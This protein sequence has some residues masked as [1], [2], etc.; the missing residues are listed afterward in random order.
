[1]ITIYGIK[2][3]DTC[4]KA[5]KWLLA[6]GIEHRFHDFRAYGLVAEDLRRWVSA[7]GWETLLNR[8]GTTWRNLPDAEKEGVDEAKA[9]SLMQASPTLIKRPVFD[10]GSDIVVGF[11]DAEQ[12][13]IRDRS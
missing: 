4:R 2:N 9:E 3:C 13:R 8:R 11:K 7:A 10:L 12:Q 6:E 5:L 1:M